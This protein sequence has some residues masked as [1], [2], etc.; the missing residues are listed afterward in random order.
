MFSEKVFGKSQ[1][2]L[3]LQT[4]F[5]FVCREQTILICV[6][7]GEIEEIAEFFNNFLI[8]VSEQGMTILYDSREKKNSSMCI[9][10]CSSQNADIYA[11]LLLSK[12]TKPLQS[13][14]IDL[15]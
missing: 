10:H 4:Y 2:I 9:V 14:R 7:F 5:H 8:L 12:A 1:Y 13:L 3:L 15:S 6:F 11:T